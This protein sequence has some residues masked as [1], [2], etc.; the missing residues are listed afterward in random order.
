MSDATPYR[1]HYTIVSPPTSRYMVTE[2]PSLATATAF[3]KTVKLLPNAHN[4]LVDFPN[5]E[6]WK[7]I[8]GR[9]LLLKVK[10]G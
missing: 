1:V 5:N 8:G 7:F 3:A 6:R 2:W 9:K 4:I 10:A